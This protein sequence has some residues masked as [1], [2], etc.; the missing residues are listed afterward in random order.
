MLD[1]KGTS[2]NLPLAE[3]SQPIFAFDWVDPEGGYA[4]QLTWTRLPQE[5]KNSHTL[6][7]EALSQDLEFQ[8]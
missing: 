5:F 3:V 1:L 8:T 7:D 2:L 4:G 6:F